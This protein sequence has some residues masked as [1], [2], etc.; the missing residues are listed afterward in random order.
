MQLHIISTTTAQP[1]IAL[2]AWILLGTAYLCSKSKLTALS[3]AGYLALPCLIFGLD[4]NRTVASSAHLYRTRLSAHALILRD[5]VRSILLQS[6]Q[7]ASKEMDSSAEDSVLRGRK[8]D[9]E[10]CLRLEFSIYI[11]LAVES[12]HDREARLFQGRLYRRSRAGKA[13]ILLLVQARGRQTERPAIESPH[14]TE[15]LVFIRDHYDIE[16]GKGNDTAS[17]PRGRQTERPAVESPHGRETRLFSATIKRW[18]G[19][20]GTLLVSSGLVSLATYAQAANERH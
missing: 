15:R 13:T 1:S 17:V 14:T 8:T 11:C 5:T 3:P 16:S 10:S 9:R 18:R 7:L 12:P 20:A 2:A 19:G 4:D 6:V